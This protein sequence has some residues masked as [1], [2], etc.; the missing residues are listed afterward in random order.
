MNLLLFNLIAFSFF[1][2]DFKKVFWLAF[3]LGI[4][5][6]LLLGNLIG[7]TSLIFLCFSL[8]IYLYQDKLSSSHLLFQLIFIVLADY[9]FTWLNAGFWSFKQFFLTIFLGLIIFPLM[10]RIKEKS[11]LELEIQRA[12]LY[13]NNHL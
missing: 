8:V 11:G 2:S 10:N 1:I 12:F 9:I 13:I 4:I 3:I 6:D 5:N 7:L